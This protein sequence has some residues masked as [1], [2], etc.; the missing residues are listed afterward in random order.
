MKTAAICFFKKR[1]QYLSKMKEATGVHD[2]GC[3]AEH[4]KFRQVPVKGRYCNGVVTL[5]YRVLLVYYLI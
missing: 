1:F 2:W 5:L 4:E 3:P